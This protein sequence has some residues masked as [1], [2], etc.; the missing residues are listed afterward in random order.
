MWSRLKGL[1]R[2]LRR[3][4]HG[5]IFSHIKV[6]DAVVTGYRVEP[7][8]DF[9]RAPYEVRVADAEGNLLDSLMTRYAPRFFYLDEALNFLEGYDNSRRILARDGKEFTVNKRTK[10]EALC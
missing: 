10:L 1:K 7:N 4:P 3:D 9:A 5:P 2:L 6:W 8:P